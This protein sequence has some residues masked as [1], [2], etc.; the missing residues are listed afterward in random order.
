MIVSNKINKYEIKNKITVFKYTMKSI[1][2]ANQSM[3]FISKFT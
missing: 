2:N 3:Q 1:K